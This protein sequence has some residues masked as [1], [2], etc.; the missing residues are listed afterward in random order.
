MKQ[1]Q[2]TALTITALLA[3]ASNSVLCRAALGE[4][5]IDPLSYTLIRV[6]SGALVL[7][8]MSLLLDLGNSAKT[9]KGWA[10]AIALATY[11]V[12]FSL[13]YVH[14]STANGALILFG[15]VQ[16][17]MVLA[18]FRSAQRPHPVEILGCLIAIG[19][20]V[21][22]VAPGLSSPSL[23][24]SALMAIAGIGWGVYSLP[25]PDA[26]NPVRQTAINF[27]RALWAVVPI[28]AIGLLV[29]LTAK[30]SP[31]GALLAVLSG[32]LASGVGYS[33]WYAALPGL[34]RTQA[35]V[36]QLSVPIIAA[37]MGA[38][39]LAELPT[40]RVYVAAA[41]ILI[42]ITVATFARKL[43]RQLPNPAPETS[44]A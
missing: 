17:T 20:L 6:L 14:L 25:G 16:I 1:L 36:V 11:A 31:V 15:A 28:T 5:I 26:V 4:S 43:R 32:A 40:V 30:V 23:S 34:S 8:L 44:D 10:P 35:A 22:L 24:G 3:F 21:Y 33:I 7:G 38:L 42:G 37:V 29:F 2:T 13:A 18:A 12:A 27:S 19:G 39:W 41:C 9:S